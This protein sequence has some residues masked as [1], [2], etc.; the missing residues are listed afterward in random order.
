MTSQ[1]DQLR[2]ELEL[3]CA[4]GTAHLR[5]MRAV[6][7]RPLAITGSLELVAR[8]SGVAALVLV[9]V[10]L[11]GSL[12]S[13]WPIAA[14]ILASSWGLG[15]LLIWRAR[16]LPVE[17]GDALALWDRAAGL[18]DRLLAADQFL[19]KSPGTQTSFVAAA[20]EDAASHIT[21]AREVDLPAPSA[22]I[23]LRRPL[24]R[25]L[26]GLLVLLAVGWLPLRTSERPCSDGLPVAEAPSDAGLRPAEPED[27]SSDPPSAEVPPKAPTERPVRTP[28]TASS[29]AQAEASD[30]SEEAKESLGRT[31]QGKSAD[32][33][34]S[35]KASQARGAPSGQSQTSKGREAKADPASKKPKPQEPAES[36]QPKQE[37]ETSGST[38]GQGSAKGSSKNPA[39]TDWSSK[40]QVS[41]PDDAEIEDD[42]ETQDEEEEQESRGGIQPSLRDRRPPV[43]R[44]LRI[45]FGNQ[46][47]PDANGRGGPSAPKKSRGV[48][49]LV[50]G[51]PIPDR[52]KGQPNPGK[53]KITQERIE[54]LKE[55][56]TLSDAGARGE[57]GGPLGRLGRLELAP[58]MQNLVRDYFL[59]RRAEAGDG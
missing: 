39:S 36:G 42:E 14:G 50:L 37:P 28:T 51:V 38:A 21:R 40:D 53:T 6:R 17:R 9:L 24:L 11:T 15:A 43:S 1:L 3:L 54:P 22:S 13:P 45:G 35:S 10:W 25:A 18:E 2:T 19:R 41:T 56:P 4:D 27:S 32:A 55:E 34:A 26:L 8:L 30:I 59:S 49:S 7:I 44:D 20:L 47:N 48:A 23:A 5:Q 58:W 12:V 46:P 31:G 33:R 29:A 52:V 16:M 57:R